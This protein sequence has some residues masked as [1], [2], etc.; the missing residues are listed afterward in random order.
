[1]VDPGEARLASSLAM[2]RPPVSAP[3]FDYR[4]ARDAVFA[5]SLPGALKLLAL[6]LIEFMPVCRPS[7]VTLAGHCGVE[8]KT[9]LRALARLE[10]MGVLV[11]ERSPGQRSR[12]VL[13]P[14]HAWRTGPLLVPVPDIG[15]G[16]DSVPVPLETRTGT[17]GGMGPV[18]TEAPTSP[19]AV[20]HEAVEADLESGLKRSAREGGTRNGPVPFAPFDA[21]L[22]P[23]RFLQYPPGWSWSAETEGAAV[24]A[25]VTAADLREHVGYWTTHAWAV[26]VTDL[27]GEL[28]RKLPDIRKRRETASA[29][30]RAAAVG[31]QRGAPV[32]PLPEPKPKHVRY[33]KEHGIDLAA[34]VADLCERKV[35]ETVGEQSYLSHIEKALVRERKRKEGS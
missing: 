9:V 18:P 11:V 8:R 1:M 26:A 33:A 16:D 29:K 28:R 35:F 14:S 15:T 6:A 17:N 21:P 32:L 2:G 5:S 27:D 12:Y 34:I 4:A 7:V 3:A 23:A 30:A 20:G 24:M 25:G 31:Q 10:R 22:L 19:I 13:Q